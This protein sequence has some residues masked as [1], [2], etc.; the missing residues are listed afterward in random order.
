MTTSFGTGAVQVVAFKLGAEEY[1]VDIGQV[2]EIN[3]L[4][5][6][7]RVPR[8]PGYVEGVINLRGQLLPIIDL[9]A[10]FEMPRVAPTRTTRIVVAEI[11]TRRVG[12][13]V[14][15]VSEVVQIPFEQVENAPEMLAGLATEYIRGVGKVDDRLI[16]LLDVTKMISVGVSDLEGLEGDAAKDEA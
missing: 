4:V 16:I 10:R 12:M 3:R 1:G 7:T 14:D 9:R 8:V 2:R 11:G 6:I 13:I 15:A 5:P